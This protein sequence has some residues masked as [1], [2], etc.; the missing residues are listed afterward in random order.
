M[1]QCTVTME[2]EDGW[3]EAEE[4]KSETAP[5]SSNQSLP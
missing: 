3:R 2:E 4:L 5:S 1:K